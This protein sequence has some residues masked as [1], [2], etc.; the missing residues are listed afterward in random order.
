MEPR[1]V[2][3][4]LFLFILASFLIS[5]ASCQSLE[6][7]RCI[8]DSDD[9]NYKSTGRV[10]LD[11][12]AIL[13][14]FCLDSPNENDLVEFS[15]DAGETIAERYPCSET[16][17][18]GRC[19]AFNWQEETNSSEE[20]LDESEYTLDE[21]DNAIINDWAEEG[22]QEPLNQS[23]CI[24]CYSNNKCYTIGERIDFG[25]GYTGYCSPTGA[26][27]PQKLSYSECEKSYECSNNLCINKQCT[28]PKEI[29]S[30]VSFF[31]KAVVRISCLFKMNESKDNCI[32][33]KI[34][35]F[36]WLQK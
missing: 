6:I 7:S 11:N 8:N 18:N 22:V 3:E 24:G 27:Y 30:K 9:L 4:I 31:K 1:S 19:V 36:G 16:C 12:G 25:E 21:S 14:D 20:A 2:L 10:Y 28:T 5:S 32:I 33:N 35:N 29:L 13:E 23:N 15:C 34:K 17:Y 26:L